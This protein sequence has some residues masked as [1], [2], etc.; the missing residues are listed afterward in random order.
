MPD[1]HIAKKKKKI[2]PSFE[3][4]LKFILDREKPVYYQITMDELIQEGLEMTRKKTEKEI[5]I[6]NA[7]KDSVEYRREKYNYI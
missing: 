1:K 7:K 6:A 2:S 4:N 5:R 3:K